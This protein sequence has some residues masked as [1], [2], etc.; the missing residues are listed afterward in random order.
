MVLQG[1]GHL[2][3]L[4]TCRNDFPLFEVCSVFTRRHTQAIVTRDAAQ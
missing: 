1:A 3:S 2:N 4:D